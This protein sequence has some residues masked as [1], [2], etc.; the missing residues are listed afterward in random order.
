MNKAAAKK[1]GV[2]KLRFPGF[3]G[4]RWNDGVLR[5]V[6]VLYQPET[7]AASQWVSTGSYPVYGA[8]GRIGSHDRYNHEDA[9]VVISC[10]GLCGHVYQTPPNSWI[11]GNGMVAKPDEEFIAKQYLYYFLSHQSFDSITSG[12]AQPQITQAALGPFKIKYPELSEQQYI[13]DCL[14]SLDACIGAETRK[15]NDLKAHKQGLMQQLFPAEGQRLPRLRFLGFGGEW[16]EKHVADLG[17]I[18]TGSTPSTTNADY[19]GGRRLFVSPADISELR[20]I[21]STKTGLTDLGFSHTRQVEVGSVLFVCIGS[22]IGKVAQN[23]VR[24]AT[25]QQI[26]SIVPFEG[27]SG[28]FIYYLLSRESGRIANLAGRQ[29]VPIINKSAFAAVDMLSPGLA[30]QKKIAN[31]LASVDELIAAEYHKVVA[32]KKHKQGLMQGLFPAMDAHAA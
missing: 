17:E 16:D 19:Y 24:C 25:N 15:L 29:A 32:L 7:L 3:K 8:G 20:F 18:V 13:A 4:A 12:S 27:V 31:C 2:P 28:D 6:C 10:R 23:H 26:N 21:E 14:S 5:D 30:E 9:Q 22:T 1:G 11:T